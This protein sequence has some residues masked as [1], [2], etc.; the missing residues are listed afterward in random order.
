MNATLE[1]L[2]SQFVQLIGP[3]AVPANLPVRAAAGPHEPATAAA[4]PAP[5]PA[6]APATVPTAA[7][8]AAV[9]T[10]TPA[11][12]KP[13][14]PAVP[15]P[16]P[17]SP[18]QVVDHALKGYHFDATVS[19]DQVVSAAS[20]LDREGFALDAVTGVDW[21]AQSQ[22]EVVYDYFHP[23]NGLRAV[24]RTRVNRAEPELATI[25]NV[26]S[27]ANWHEREAHD[28]FGLRFTGHPNLTPFLLPEDATFHPLRK[29]YQP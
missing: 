3:A 22:M 12:P 7:A 17:P 2:T 6:A 10:G 21:I 19:P 24:V 18:V 13:A 29:D 14:A 1:R 27:G 4:I 11:A 8:S 23:V 15:P 26:F 16:P 9:A 20:I 5:V 28:F 25:S